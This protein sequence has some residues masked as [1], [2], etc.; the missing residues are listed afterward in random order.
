MTA[1]TSSPAV[2][3]ALDRQVRSVRPAVSD[4]PL[5]RGDEVVEDVLLLLAHARFVP[6]L[7]VFASAPKVRDRD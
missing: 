2:G 7:A 3:P 6:L 5:G 4:Q 1:A